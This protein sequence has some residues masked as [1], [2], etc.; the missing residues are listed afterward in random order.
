L[1]LNPFYRRNNPIIRLFF[2]SDF[3]LVISYESPGSFV[4]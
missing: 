2:P 4:T 1:A 3:T